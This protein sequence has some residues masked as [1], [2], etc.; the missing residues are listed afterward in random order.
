MK[1]G[2]ENISPRELQVM[3]SA[4]RGEAARETAQALR[5][6]IDTVKDHRNSARARLGARNATHAVAILVAAGLVEVAA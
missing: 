6:A 2:I 5:I 1:L 3:Q 4:A